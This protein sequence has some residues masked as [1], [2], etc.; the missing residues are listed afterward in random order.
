MISPREGSRPETGGFGAAELDTPKGEQV[1]DRAARAASETKDALAEASRDLTEQA[2]AA[3][4]E[5]RGVAG[6]L[7]GEAKGRLSE[8]V[9]ARKQEVVGHVSSVGAAV[10]DAADR[11]EEDHSPVACYVRTAAEGLDRAADRLRDA[12]LG[13]I[14]GDAE[15]F[16]RRHPEVV[17]GGLFLVGVGIARF[18]KASSDDRR[19]DRSAS[20]RNRSS[21]LRPTGDFGAMRPVAQ[22]GSSG[23][24]PV[25]ESLDTGIATPTDF[26]VADDQ[27]AHTDASGYGN[28][29]EFAPPAP[30]SGTAA[31]ELDIPF[32]QGSPR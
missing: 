3:G 5:L 32:D 11:L 30:T 2:K 31:T 1:K 8:Q 12:D 18:L 22:Y 16:A 6:R 10:R 4:D 27:F 23:P 15:R 29:S 26:S 14:Y 20:G 17:L 13:D 21:G 19:R 25:R 7:T 9:L 24:Y 28:V